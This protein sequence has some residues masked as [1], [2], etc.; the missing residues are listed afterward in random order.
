MCLCSARIQ[1]SCCC[2]NKSLMWPVAAANAATAMLVSTYKHIQKAQARIV[3]LSL[4]LSHI[5]THTH[6]SNTF[7]YNIL[8]SQIY[9]YICIPS[10][11]NTERTYNAWMTLAFAVPFHFVRVDILNIGHIPHTQ[12]LR[13][14]DSSEYSVILDRG[15][16]WSRWSSTYYM[17]INKCNICLV[18]FSNIWCTHSYRRKK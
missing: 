2:C 6:T 4:F 16:E 8:H 3:S 10:E 1:S 14:I 18:S 15:P 13:L 11:N 7:I 5:H 12:F 9:I 17:H